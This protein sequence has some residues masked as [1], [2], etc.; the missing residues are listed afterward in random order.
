MRTV[1]TPSELNREVRLHLEAGFPRLWVEGEISNLARPPS[2]HLYFTVKDDRAQIS[3]TLFRSHAR[4]LSFRPE[5]GHLVQV[6]G[7]LGLYETRGQFQLVAD[8]LEAA[9][10]G[11]LRAAFEALKRRLEEDGLFRQ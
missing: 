10:E 6:R 4:Q 7:K 8:G 3:V 2:G 5:N 11:R 1:Y 9:G